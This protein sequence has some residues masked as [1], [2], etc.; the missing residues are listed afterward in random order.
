MSE[1]RVFQSVGAVTKRFC[2]VCS[3]I[4]MGNRTWPCDRFLDDERS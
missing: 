3:Q 4:K 1:G 2:T